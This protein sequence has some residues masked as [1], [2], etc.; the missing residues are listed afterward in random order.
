LT[1][2]EVDQ[3]LLVTNHRYYPHFAQYLASQERLKRIQLLDD[4]TP[5]P[6]HRL[7]A[8]GDLLWLQKQGLLNHHVLVCPSDTLSSLK[9]RRLINLYRAKQGFCTVV[10]DLHD[11]AQVVGRLGCVELKGDQ[12]VGFAE[13]PTAPKTSL[14]GV[15]FYLYPQEVLKRLSEYQLSGGSMDAPGS[16]IEWLLKQNIPVW[17]ELLQDQGVRKAYYYDV[18]TREVYESLKREWTNLS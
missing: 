7:G 11:K 1:V 6:E 17:A 15:P 3:I 9:L 8:L 4:G 10:Y 5:D 16:I 18:G 13:K 12:V 2:K 14:V